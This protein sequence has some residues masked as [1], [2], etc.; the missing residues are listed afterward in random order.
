M[1][2]IVE[3]GPSDESMGLIGSGDPGDFSIESISSGGK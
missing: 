3:G 1:A 2:A